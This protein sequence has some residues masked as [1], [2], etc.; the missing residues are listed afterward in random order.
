MAG[1][2]ATYNSNSSRGIVMRQEVREYPI[3]WCTRGTQF[4][5]HAKYPI[6]VIAEHTTTD[7]TLKSDFYIEENSQTDNSSGRVVVGV[8][9]NAREYFVVTIFL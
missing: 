2:F 6:T 9:G 7:V 8:R 3:P 1:S 4:G 5:D